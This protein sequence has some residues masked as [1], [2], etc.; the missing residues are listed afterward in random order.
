MTNPALPPALYLP[1][2]RA[3]RERGGADI[4][5]RHTP[6][7]RTALVA[8]TALDRL[9]SCCGEH[10]P[11]ALVNTEHLGKIHAAKPYDVIVLDSPLPEPLRHRKELV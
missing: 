9:V 6:D 4:E 2:G 3:T 10:Q 11:W 8:F 5:L 7:G 1:T